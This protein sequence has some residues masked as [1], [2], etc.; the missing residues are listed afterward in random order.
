MQTQK[1]RA[2]VMLKFLKMKDQ[3]SKMSHKKE[4]PNCGDSAQ[5]GKSIGG[6]FPLFEK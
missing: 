3:F 1:Y 6:L 5:A 2:P 4:G